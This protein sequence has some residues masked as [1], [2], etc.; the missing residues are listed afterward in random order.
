[1]S[2]HR[3][4]LISQK[5][6]TPWIAIA[7]CLYWRPMVLDLPHIRSIIRAVWDSEMI[8]PSLVDTL[9]TLSHARCGVRQGDIIS[10]IIFNI[11][12][13]AIVREWYFR[14]DDDDTQT[15]FYADDGSLSGTDP[16]RFN[17]VSLLSLIFSNAWDY[18]S[19][20]IKPKQ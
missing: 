12:V 17:R 2:R 4:L 15:I 1:M 10:P 5:P 14:M 8:F 13:N 16:V 18:I 6:M 9:V 11:I 20:L 3:S 7:H 19:I